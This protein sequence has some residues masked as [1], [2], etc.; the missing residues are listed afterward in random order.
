MRGTCVTDDLQNDELIDQLKSEFDQSLATGAVLPD[1]DKRQSQATQIVNL[2][3]E[4]AELF[5]DKNREAFCT[6]KQDGQTKRVD[7]KAFK[8]WVTDL[9]YKEQK[10]CIRDQSLREAVA[11]L[12]G[13]ARHSGEKFEASL[14]VAK[15][16]DE[17]VIDLC[18]HDTSE[19]VRVSAGRWV[20]GEAGGARFVRTDYMQPLPQ[21]AKGGSV[22]LLWKYI[23]V[24]ESARPLVIAWILDSFRLDTPFPVL[25]L[26][27]GQ[28][29][30]K[31][32]TQKLIRRLIDPNTCELRSAPK[33]PEDYFVG[34][35]SNWLL[36]YENLSHL[37]GQAQD[38]LC[39][40]STGGGYATRRL[41]TN[42]EEAILD[43][44]RPVVINGICPIVTQQDLIDRTVSIELPA[45]TERF[46]STS[47]LESFERDKSAIFGGLMD[48]FAEALQALESVVIDPKTAPRLI[49]FVKFGEALATVL[50]HA[51]GEFLAIFTESRRSAIE[52]TLDSSPVAQAALEWAQSRTSDFCELP[53]KQMFNLIEQFKP[54]GCEAW[55]RSVKGFGDALRR[56]APALRQ[57]GFEFK[58]LGKRGGVVLWAAIK[59]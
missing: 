14:R 19:C 55:P 39:V 25:E 51:Q 9:F 2:V 45:L 6:S 56:A 43:V 29:S 47:L 3:S 58:S 44:K 27:G 31:S 18:E 33:N 5:H 52:R 48:L 40:L 15:D 16:G 20:I 13:I 17:Y 46:E 49:E 36:S 26:I 38:N 34:G 1:D 12:S 4:R 23:N 7:S 54:V 37:S 53:L 8:D 59:L 32:Q 30:G 35:N 21:P 22:A 28:G 24:P 41:Y 11:A 42:T 50:G 57:L 10:V